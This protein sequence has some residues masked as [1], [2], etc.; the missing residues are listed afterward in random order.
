MGEEVGQ[1]HC[2]EGPLLTERAVESHRDRQRERAAED[3]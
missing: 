2:R 1:P 3:E